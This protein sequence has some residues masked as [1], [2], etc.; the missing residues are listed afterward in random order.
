MRPSAPLA[1]RWARGIRPCGGRFG[2]GDRRRRRRPGWPTGSWPRS[3]RRRRRPGPLMGQ[4]GADVSG[5]L[6]QG[7]R[8]S[9]RRGAI[10]DR[11][12]ALNRAMDRTRRERPAGSCCITH[13]RPGHE[14]AT[15]TVA[16]DARAL[17][18]ALAEATAAT[19]DL[20][21][22]ASEPAA[23][24][25][26][27]VL[28]AATGPERNPAQAASVTG[29]GSVAATVSVPSLDSLAPDT[30]AA[31]AMLQQVGDRLTTGVRP[32]R[33]RPATR[34]GSC[35]GRHSP[36]PKSPLTRQ[37]KREPDGIKNQRSSGARACRGCVPSGPGG[38]SGSFFFLFSASR[39]APRGA[40]SGPRAGRR[41]LATGPARRGRGRHRR[42]PA[43]PDE[44]LSQISSGR[45][46]PAASGGASLARLGKI[47]AFRAVARPDRDAPGR[48]SDRRARRVAGRCRD[49]GSPASARGPR[50]REPG[51]RDSARPGARSGAPRCD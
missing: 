41:P 20:A 2:R 45:R 50:R 8:R 38:R 47:P 39:C 48:E 31:G 7:W 11:S 6:P 26:R 30:A 40:T 42:R 43:R 9:L 46:S 14:A 25:S 36:S 1:A 23:R 24:I 49:S 17:N 4:S 33:I 13:R 34:S 16:G 21:R 28:D 5:R 19:W 32:F 22:S 51:P 15:R 37:P 35:S 10:G 27:Q 29:S 18:V 12:A 44:R 3:R